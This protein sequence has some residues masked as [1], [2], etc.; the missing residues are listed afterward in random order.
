MAGDGF[1][2]LFF[3]ESSQDKNRFRHGEAAPNAE[4][5][6][7][8]AMPTFTYHGN[9]IHFAAYKNHI[10]LYPTPSGIEK[11]SDQLASY[12]K[13]KGSIRFPLDQPIP[14]ELIH[15][16]VKFRVQEN[17]ARI[18]ANKRKGRG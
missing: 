2:P 1:Q 6:I 15:E 9:L 10:G 8:Y 13:A 11:F 5:T 12:K 3:E 16:I 17:Q 14:Y 7:K 18:E 4:E